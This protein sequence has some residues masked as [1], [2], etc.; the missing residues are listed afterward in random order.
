M[1]DFNIMGD[2][3]ELTTTRRFDNKVI[4]ALVAGNGMTGMGHAL[5]YHTENLMKDRTEPTHPSTT[6]DRETV[7]DAT[8]LAIDYNTEMKSTTVRIAKEKVYEDTINAYSGCYRYPGVLL[9]PHLF[10]KQAL[11]FGEFEDENKDNPRIPTDI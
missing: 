11:E 8:E 7:L 3:K 10:G 6:Q 9:Q 1:R 2:I 5:L 4:T